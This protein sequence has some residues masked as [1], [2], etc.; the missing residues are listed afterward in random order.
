MEEWWKQLKHE[1]PSFDSF[2][3]SLIWMCDRCFNN[4]VLGVVDFVLLIVHGFLWDID[5]HTQKIIKASS[6]IKRR[7]RR[8]YSLLRNFSACAQT[9]ITRIEV[10]ISKASGSR[11]L[12]T[13]SSWFLCWCFKPPPW[14]VQ[15]WVAFPTSRAGFPRQFEVCVV[16]LTTL[17]LLPMPFCN[18]RIR[19]ISNDCHMFALS[20]S[21]LRLLTSTSAHEEFQIADR[22]WS[23]NCSC[24]VRENNSYTYFIIL[25]LYVVFFNRSRLYKAV[26]TV[27]VATK[28]PLLP[29]LLSLLLLPKRS[30]ILKPTKY[31]QQ[32][33]IRKPKANAKHINWILHQIISMYDHMLPYYHIY[34]YLIIVVITYHDVSRNWK[35]LPVLGWTPQIKS[36]NR[37]VTSSV[38][39]R[40]PTIQL[41]QSR[42]ILSY[43]TNSTHSHSIEWNQVSRC[44]LRWTWAK[45][46][47]NQLV[48]WNICD[49]SSQR[50][51]YQDY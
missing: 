1:L 48:G 31:G 19:S 22:T 40:Y 35:R 26:L 32:L 46:Q 47:P 18:L 15:A 21:P 9:N 33:N 4:S 8:W 41:T 39:P 49:W 30:Y 51:T 5:C 3:A 25:Y 28:L 20:G 27:A 34:L 7:C 50:R 2:R 44:S 16:R 38:H 23:V 10:V 43:L 37:C 36:C 12:Q 13:D 42:G 45:T 24:S 11:Y 17:L 6:I 14:C 29:L